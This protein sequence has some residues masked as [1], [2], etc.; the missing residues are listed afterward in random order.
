MQRADPSQPWS[1][2]NFYWKEPI[3]S[4]DKRADRAAYMREYGRKMREAN[5]R[6]HKALHIKKLYGITID[7]YDAMLAQQNGCCAICSKEEANEIMGKTTSLAID[8]CHKTGK[9]RALL[10]SNCNRALGLFNDDAELLAK[11]H[12]YVLRHSALG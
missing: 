1:K 7:Q 9:I 5:P 8:H 11:A 6:Y 2:D 4:A 12:G 10:C 3:V